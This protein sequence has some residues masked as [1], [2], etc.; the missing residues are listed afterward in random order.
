MPK[1]DFTPLR[2]L[3]F[4]RLY[5]PAGM[6]TPQELPSDGDVIVVL[7][8]TQA[9]RGLHFDAL[10]I[11]AASAAA[12]LKVSHLAEYDISHGMPLPPL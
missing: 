6:H 12:A 1:P 9:G 7:Q 5:L 2:F 3:G 4:P 11:A 8:W 10:E